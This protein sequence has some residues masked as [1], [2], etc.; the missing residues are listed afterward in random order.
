MLK[1]YEYGLE[2]TATESDP[3]LSLSRKQI[4]FK[5][6]MYFTAKIFGVTQAKALKAYFL[7][8]HKERSPVERGDEGYSK[9]TEIFHRNHVETPALD[10]LFSTNTVPL[11]CSLLVIAGPQAEFQPEESEKISQYLDQGGRLFALFD[12]YS[13]AH[14]LG[15]EGVL[16]KWNVNV[17]HSMI[18]DPDLAQD[19]EHTGSAFA[20][21]NFAPHDIMKSLAG[22]P[23]EFFLARPIERIKASSQTGADEPQVTDLAFS[24]VNSRLRDR[25]SLDSAAYPLMVAVEKAAAKGVLTERGTTR[26]VIVGDSMLLDNKLIPAGGNEDFADAAINW[27]LERTSFLS[28]VGPRP[29]TQYR[30]QMTPHETN[31]VKGLLLGAIPGGIL[32]FGGLVWLRRRK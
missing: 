15:L 25:P 19:P 11:D 32:L 6:E 31:T 28:G 12:A 3:K 29:I 5:G 24:S 8:G 23:M 16:A 27:L 9:I 4:V 30:L 21:T 20:V 17:T 2:N 22:S 10:N 18:L 26:M 7:Q 1:P 13:L 14:R